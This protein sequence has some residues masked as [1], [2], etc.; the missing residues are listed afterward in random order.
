MFVLIASHT[1]IAFY[2]RPWPGLK[3][4]QGGDPF[5]VHGKM[6]HVPSRVDGRLTDLIVFR[7][8]DIML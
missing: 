8:S 1:L 7:I 3:A 5:H 2:E 4:V 6:L